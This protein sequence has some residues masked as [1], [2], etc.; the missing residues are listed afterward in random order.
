VILDNYKIYK[1]DII[2][3]DPKSAKQDCLNADSLWESFVKNEKNTDQTWSYQNYNIFSLTS[4]SF[5]FY[6]LY[7]EICECFR[8][9]SKHKGPAWMSAWLN[10]HSK[11][12]VLDWHFHDEEYHGYVVIDKH[13]SDNPIKTRTVFHNY[14]I[15]NE[16]G[17]IYMGKGG[18]DHKVEVL[19]P[20]DGVRH[21]LA[22]NI[23]TFNGDTEKTE[24]LMK[25]KILIEVKDFYR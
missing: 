17:N 9:F 11:D 20:Y 2:I 24:R 3:K 5:F 7:K 10:S 1:S 22:F 13:F 12:E 14:E 16:L 4:G 18:F 25:E 6:E 21:T 15:Q 8:D 23:F 19:Q